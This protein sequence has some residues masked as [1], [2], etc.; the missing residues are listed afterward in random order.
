MYFDT[1]YNTVWE[2]AEVTK[3]VTSSGRKFSR[4]SPQLSARTSRSTFGHTA[5]L[6]SDKCVFAAVPA[7]SQGYTALSGY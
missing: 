1:F 6:F 3:R 7:G 2:L 5:I 4:D